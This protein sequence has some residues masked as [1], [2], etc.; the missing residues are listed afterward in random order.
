MYNIAV[1]VLLSFSDTSNFFTSGIVSGLAE[2]VPILIAQGARVHWT[3][4]WWIATL[5]FTQVY[6]TFGSTSKV[7]FSFRFMWD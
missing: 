3:Q 5:T 6:E 7:C 1:S 4:P 2:A